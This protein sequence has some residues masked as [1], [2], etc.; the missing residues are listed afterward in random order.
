[1]PGEFEIR[2][3]IGDLLDSQAARYADRE[4]LVH[5]ETGARFTYRELKDEC[6]RVGLPIISIACWAFRL[7]PGPCTSRRKLLLPA[8]TCRLKS[9]PA[10]PCYSR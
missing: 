10:R 8:W 1:M 2:V 9:P 4:A 6:D 7:I 5:V 3:T